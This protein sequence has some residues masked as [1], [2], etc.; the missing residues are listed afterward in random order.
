MG[1]SPFGISRER[2]GPGER[3]RAMEFRVLGPTEMW[4]DRQQCDLG[5]ARERNILAILLLTP[6]TIV[7]ADA[8]IE[9]LWDAR[10]PAK[11][12][13][14]LSA[15][16]ARLRR[17]L[18]QAACDGVRLTGRASGYMLDIDPETVDLH[19]FRR[20][21]H[22]ADAQNAS[23]DTDHAAR[24]LREADGLWRGQALAGIRG[25]WV[26]RMR[27]SIEDERRAAIAQRVRYELDLG[28][29]ADLV[30]ELGGL[31]A[32]YGL[33]ETFI[34]QQM[35]ALYGSGRLADA[36]SLYRQTRRRIKDEQGTEPGAE[37]AELHLR[38]LRHD[39]Q[40]AIGLVR[41]PVPS[42]RS[43]S[44]PSARSHPAPRTFPPAGGELAK[45]ATG[46]TQPATTQPATTGPA[47]TGPATSGPATSGP[48][49]ASGFGLSYH[50]LEPDHQRFFSRL[51][52]NPSPQVS[53]HGAAALGG[54]TIVEA[55]RALTALLDQHLLIRDP[56]GQFG[57]RDLSRGFAPVLATQEDTTSEQR[58]AVGRLLDYYLH[59]ADQADRMLHPFRRR[60]PVRVTHPP[61]AAPTLTTP[62]E[63]AQW[64][65]SEWRNILQAAEHAGRHHWQRQC[66][67][68][69]HVLAGFVEIRGYWDEAIAAHAAALQACRDL[70]D[71]A[72]IAQA[73][74]ELSV[75]SQQTGRY[76]ATLA[77]AQDA[78][79]IFGSVDDSRGLAD[80]LDQT[81][82]VHQRA[83]RYREAL[84][85]F[86][87]A[88]DLYSD[89]GDKHGT[90]TALSHTGIAGWHLGR[91]P[92]AAGH[93][94]EAL[95]LY[96]DV[97][98]RRGEAKTLNNLGKMQLHGG[99]HRDALES[100]S[101]SLDIFRDIGGVQ[102]H[103]IL[104]QN[105]GSVYHYKGD[106]DQGITAYK[107][108]LASYRELGDLPDQADV[109]NDLGAIYHSADCHAEA[110]LHYRQAQLIAEEIGDQ[111]Q[112]LIALRG[113]A[114]VQHG[115]GRYGEAFDDYH[116]ALRLVRQIG[117]PYEEAKVLEGI[118]ETTL[119]AGKPHAARIFFRQALD[120]FERLGV[121]DAESARIRLDTT[122][123]AFSRSTSLS[124]ASSRLLGLTS[125]AMQ[126]SSRL[127]ADRPVLQRTLV[128][129]FP[130][131]KH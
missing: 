113:T 49:L 28:R 77:L 124:A 24:L 29:H 118:A 106:Y 74:L 127:Q 13:E 121:P 44:A 46:P 7:S 27:Y 126:P 54:S 50:A 37:L 129:R 103:A 63:A 80:A 86:R 36:L 131:G 75:V 78:A 81:G 23:G 10:P 57:F 99:Y 115:C 47:T 107:R 100:F 96:R 5:P 39:P 119:S 26:A 58:Q 92:D 73:S 40:L 102:S 122:D 30:G 76:E 101:Q 22:H 93:L 67:E 19:R 123:P 94:R 130:P 25:D 1:C 109:L 83:G 60:M 17:S 84:A 31:I 6:R 105:I 65:E 9:R 71:P 72:M 12:R 82:L 111:T 52:V 66:A 98:D 62:E 95:T 34:A 48:G 120:I 125:N 21:R 35:T 33:D 108:A 45:A 2:L 128:L 41:R 14:S 43:H 56:A 110:L 70:A 89:S 16:V 18:R 87:E 55:Q 64:L 69:T 61:A 53:L 59:V 15:Y 11:A 4:S 79:S 90:A 104:H 97:G 91:Y 20:L 42:A 114:A 117:D 112:Q 32:Q 38:I 68:L 51:S 85:Y 88:R 8:L 3:L 116:A